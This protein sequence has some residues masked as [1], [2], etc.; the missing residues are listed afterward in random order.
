M[1]PSS[2]PA[3]EDAPALDRGGAPQSLFPSPYVLK[4]GRARRS[5]NRPSLDVVI[6]EGSDRQRDQA[7]VRIADLRDSGRFLVNQKGGES[8]HQSIE[9]IVRAKAFE[10]QFA[11]QD[12]MPGYFFQDVEGIGEVQTLDIES[13]LPLEPPFE[14]GLG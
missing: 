4:L 8:R 11:G 10:R 6:L 5:C 7:L 2:L 1:R 13:H 3:D 9:L 14:M 12:V